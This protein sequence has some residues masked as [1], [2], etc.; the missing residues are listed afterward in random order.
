METKK[1]IAR[2]STLATWDTNGLTAAPYGFRGK[3][4]IYSITITC[5]LEHDVGQ[6]NSVCSVESA[7]SNLDDKRCVGEGQCL[8]ICGILVETDV[9]Q[10]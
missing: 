7:L 10:R 8:E 5:M 9:R 2:C 3:K 6:L 1:K 4:R